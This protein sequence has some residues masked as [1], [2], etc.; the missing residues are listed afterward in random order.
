LVYKCRY[1]IGMYKND[2]MVC[3]IDQFK[4]C[5]KHVFP[6]NV[7]LVWTRLTYNVINII[8]YM[9]AGMRVFLLSIQFHWYL[10]FKSPTFN[11]LCWYIVFIYNVKS[12][13]GLGKHRKC[14]N[15]ISV[16]YSL[17][18]YISDFVLCDIALSKVA[19]HKILS[20]TN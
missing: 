12:Y 9:S 8:L 2:C 3:N 17:I 15:P 16:D 5:W 20:V 7:S 18:I 11:L 4:N 19:D 10:F 14:V 13:F 6:T 1:I